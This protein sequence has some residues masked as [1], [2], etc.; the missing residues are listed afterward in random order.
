MTKK[1]VTKSAGSAT[2]RFKGEELEYKLIK[3]N[4]KEFFKKN[5]PQANYINQSYHFSVRLNGR[6]V[7]TAEIL[8]QG[9]RNA[10]IKLALKSLRQELGIKIKEKGE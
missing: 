7:L 2:N 3:R 10:G 1:K 4:L 8:G 9:N 5:E 6:D